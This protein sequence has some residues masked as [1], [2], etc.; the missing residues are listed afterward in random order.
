MLLP[1]LIRVVA[2]ACEQAAAEEDWVASL[3]S[4][5]QVE[6]VTVD[7]QLQPSSRR[8]TPQRN[9]VIGSHDHSG[10]IGSHMGSTEEV[11]ADVAA[12]LHGVVL[13]R[14]SVAGRGQGRGYR[15]LRRRS[16]TIAR[17]GRDRR[18]KADWKTVDNHWSLVNTPRPRDSLPSGSCIIGTILR[19]NDCHSRCHCAASDTPAAMAT[20]PRPSMNSSLFTSM[21]ST[22]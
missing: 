17:F 1:G 3:L 2:Q 4:D 22:Q 8:K 15:R 6:T 21:S 7:G 14:S 16:P 9:V 11:L 20:K 18:W 19:S 12:G 5:V 13:E 10:W